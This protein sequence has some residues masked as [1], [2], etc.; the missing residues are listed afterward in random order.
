M[1]TA[2]VKHLA[3]LRAAVLVLFVVLC[4]AAPRTALAACNHLVSSKSTRS[5]NWNH[6]DRLIVGDTHSMARDDQPND[7]QPSPRAPVRSPCSGLGCSSPIPVSSSTASL[8]SGGGLDRWGDFTAAIPNQVEG[9]VET[10]A[11]EP[12]P[13]S[14]GHGPAIFH[15]P[16]EQIA[17]FSSELF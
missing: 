15:P 5:L 12:T 10:T 1:K 8:A 17:R 2:S 16:P 4:H 7:P 6:L 14:Q 3:W 9:P 11:S 13:H